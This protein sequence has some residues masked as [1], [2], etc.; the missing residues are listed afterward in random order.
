MKKTILILCCAFFALGAG[1]QVQF[2]I[3]GGLNTFDL[4]PEQLLI[5]NENDVEAFTLSV[6]E[7]NYGYQ[8]GLFGRVGLGRLYLQPEVLFNSSSMDYHIED[9]SSNLGQTVF[10]ESYQN[11]DIPIM[12]GL[13][14]GPLNLHGGPVGHVFLNSS[15]ELFDISGYEQKF[16]EMTW[17]WQAGAG[18]D[19]WKL[20]LDFR[21]EGAFNRKQ[22][23]HI[24]FFGQDYNFDQSPG[25]FVASVGIRF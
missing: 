15:S 6:K 7:A 16:D 9:F 18:L 8:V 22:G 21:Y 19:L 23:D 12:L 20:M 1:A 11:L 2:G 24:S 3:K 25:R 14:L 4:A 10:N 13:K 17:G 5:T